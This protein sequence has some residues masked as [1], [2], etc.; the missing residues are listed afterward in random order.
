MDWGEEINIPSKLELKNKQ[1]PTLTKTKNLT[2]RNKIKSIKLIEANIE[3]PEIKKKSNKY[4]EF[5]IKIPD[6]LEYETKTGK[7]K[8]SSGLTKTGALKTKNKIKSFDLIPLDEY[9][10]D[11]ETEKKQIIKIKDIPYVLIEETKQ[12]AKEFKPLKLKETKDEIIKR[13]F[14]ELIKYPFSAFPALRN[15]IYSDS[16]SGYRIMEYLSYAT[17]NMDLSENEIKTIEDNI[18]K[19]IHYLQEKFKINNN[20]DYKYD[21]YRIKQGKSNF[22]IGLKRYIN[23]LKLI[24]LSSDDYVNIELL[25][26]SRNFINYIFREHHYVS[27]Y[28]I[29]KE[30]N[31]DL[32]FE[33][34]QD[35]R[36]HIKNLEEEFKYISKYDNEKWDYIIEKLFDSIK[37]IMNEKNK[38][39]FKLQ[40]D[41]INNT[42]A[43]LTNM[44]TQK[45]KKEIINKYGNILKQYSE[46][47]KM[48]DNNEEDL[49]IDLYP[50]KSTRSIKINNYVE[51]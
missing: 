17:Y 34:S 14:K 1:V 48:I 2:T 27:W 12:K 26:L 49:L 32:N 10:F 31:K 47:K 9:N 28:S 43:N 19:K 29:V 51:T 4:G 13:N 5:E 25:E 42:L 22:L 36:N 41:A 24:K 40:Y 8:K 11:D 50:K 20:R 37:M 21:I 39:V 3:K 46:F 33:I 18:E 7:I 30:I 15:I 6:E 35:Y 23:A 44:L 16:Y 45:K 38:E